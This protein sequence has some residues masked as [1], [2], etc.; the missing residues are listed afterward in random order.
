MLGLM[1]R[2]NY[3]HLYYFWLVAREGSV[4]KAAARLGLAQPT[5]SGQIRTLE[6]EFGER[7][8]EKAGRGL[9]LT[10]MGRVAFRFADQI[11]SLGEELQDTV[12]RGAPGRPLRLTIGLADV[13]TKPMAH[14]LIRPMLKPPHP[15]RVIV[16]E[17]SPEKLLAGLVANELDVLI[18]DSPPGPEAGVRVFSHRLSECGVVLLATTE[19]ARRHRRGFP[20]SLDGAPFLLPGR[21]TGLR[22]GLDQWF[23]DQGIRPYVVGEIDDSA[24]VFEFGKSGSGIFAVPSI[25]EKDIRRQHDLA[26]VGRV[27]EVRRELF[28]VGLQGRFDHPAVVALIARARGERR[29][30]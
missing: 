7:L 2:I 20:Q 23:H 1:Q 17:D 19:L 30:R 3:N 27:E 21:T 13:V 12:N 10:E 25:V 5:L 9:R 24:L 16:R 6:S 14:R 11:F 15:V 18:L 26:R 28:A 4:S 29:V 8:F 22:Q